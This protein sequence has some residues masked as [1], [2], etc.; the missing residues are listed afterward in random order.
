MKR[1][2]SPLQKATVY[3]QVHPD[4]ISGFY[5]PQSPNSDVSSTH[6]A[7]RL[8]PQLWEQKLPAQVPNYQFFS[9]S[10]AADLA[11][12]AAISIARQLIE[13]T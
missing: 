12:V 3:T 13:F 8:K 4:C 6:H 9:E 5:A 2:L 10:A 7:W 11:F 1:A